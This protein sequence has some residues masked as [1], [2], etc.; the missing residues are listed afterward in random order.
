MNNVISLVDLKTS[1][2]IT[3]TTKD[4]YLD[5]DIKMVSDFMERYISKSIITKRFIEYHSGGGF[6]WVLTKNYPIYKV[7]NIYDEPERNFS[8]AVA[9]VE[10]DTWVD[11]N[12]GE[13]NLVANQFSFSKARGNVKIDYWAGFTRFLVEDE[14]NNY[15]DVTDGGGTA[16]IEIPIQ[17]SY[18]A[19][20]YSAE[21]LATAIQTALNA[22]ATLTETYTVTY[23]NS[24]QKFTIAATGTFSLL[25][26]SGT[27]TT[28]NIG[29][30]IGFSV[31]AND[32]SAATYIADNVAIGAP[33]DLKLAAM[34]I[35]HFNYDRA[36]TGEGLMMYSQKTLD[37][38]DYTY[39]NSNLPL[40]AKKVL[41]S[42]RKG[43]L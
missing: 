38:R 29:T 27:N 14:G 7:V 30:L 17:S 8:A 40:M 9:I 4:T 35:C 16:A 3:T 15:M 41:D 13:I 39:L 12:I 36:K 26:Q 10:G 2:A 18:A 6:A 19:D 28:K 33:E 5:M 32:A 21:D 22:D 23:N 11:Y 20:G 42:Y 34:E 25:W 24:T 37:N 43:Y 31:A 1:L